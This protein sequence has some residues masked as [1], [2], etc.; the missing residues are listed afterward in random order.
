MRARFGRIDIWTGVLA[1]AWAVIILLLIWPLSTILF[2]SFRDN[3]TGAFSL[4]NY[5]DVF[6]LRSYRRAIGNTL[7][8]GFGGMAGSLML[9]VSLA[10]LVTRYRVRGRALIQTLAVVALVSPP[11]IGAY[12]WIVLFGA[13]GVARNALA[14]FGVSLPSIYGATG[15]ILVF[16]FKFFPHVFL[17]VSG[18]LAAVNRSVEEA[19]E[20]LGV[21]PMRRLLTITLPLITPSISAAALLTFVLSIAD[22][23]TPRLI[24]RDLSVLATEAF[25]Q[26]GSEMGGNPG[27]ASTLSL[28]LIAISMT[29]VA[30]QRRATRRNV[31]AGNLLR[32]PEP[33]P[34]IGWRGVAMHIAAYAIVL[35]GATPAITAVIFSFR[36][37]S[38]PV[39]QPGFSL[40][41]YERVIA[42]V[43][44]PIWNTL[45]YS[46]ASVITIVVIGTLI[47]YLVARRPQPATAAL[48]GVLMIPYVV[49]GVVMGIAFIAQFNAPPVAITGTGLII[50]LAIFIRR[51]PYSVR[52]VAAALKQLSANLE[53]A[54][55]SLGLSPGRAFLKVTAPL[56]A[57]GIM[58]G[59]LMSLVTA[60]NELSSSLVLYVGGTATMPVRIYLAVLDGE[61]GL[62]SALASILLLLTMMAV[63][64]AFALSGRRREV[65][66]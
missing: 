6:M 32:R 36:R 57:P 9:G 1:L 3:D 39:F 56:I 28:V 24:G 8:V 29:L 62:A 20:S 13:N 46:A 55:I 66:L 10:F 22:F 60:M 27:M 11:F 7:L 58:A 17:I 61:Y 65:L 31:Y 4:G 38:G 21:S 63:G 53:D 5:V 15:V 42:T 37:T 23:G 43:S 18:A 14:S 48:D 54:A 19:A 50:I 41:S 16:S 40:Q 30:L 64:A 44:T 59:A 26:F 34:A 25:V 12:A 51:L 35:V 47:G 52:S 45:V 2:A 49:P 33:K